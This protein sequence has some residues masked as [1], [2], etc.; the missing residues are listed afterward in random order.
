[1][2][3]RPFLVKGGL[4]GSNPG[5]VV[6]VPHKCFWSKGE[7]VFLKFNFH[8]I[9]ETVS[10]SAFARRVC[11]KNSFSHIL[12]PTFKRKP[13]VRKQYP[14]LYNALAGAEGSLPSQALTPPPRDLH[15][16]H[17]QGLGGPARCRLVQLAGLGDRVL[18]EQRGQLGQRVWPLLPGVVQPVPAGSRRQ[19]AG[20]CREGPGKEGHPADFQVSVQGE[21]SSPPPSP[22][23]N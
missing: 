20:G 15:C 7:C 2:G 16:G 1:M 23:G 11:Y 3:A 6:C 10:P 17:L 12:L 8:A 13:L 14:W 5:D 22:P 21:A 18:C 9:K 19:G 4:L